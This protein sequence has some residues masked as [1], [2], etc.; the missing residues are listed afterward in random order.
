MSDDKKK[1][2]VLITL[3]V[4]L[5]SVGAFQLIPPPAPAPA[6]KPSA[7]KPPVTA[8]KPS[9]RDATKPGVPKTAEPAKGALATKPGATTGP[10]V[11][12]V[13]PKKPKDAEV[14]EVVAST[15]PNLAVVAPLAPRDPFDVPASV[16]ASNEPVPYSASNAN[17]Q[18]TKGANGLGKAFGAMMKGMVGALPEVK[19]GGTVVEPVHPTPPPAEAAPEP[20]F[21][22]YLVGVIVGRQ[23]AAV[24]QDAQ[25]HQRLITAGSAIDGDSS[26][27]EVRP[28]IAVVKFRGK[29]IQLE[30]KGDHP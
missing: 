4:A 19:A 13:D 14:K 12:I 17:N 8:G 15:A 28:G 9:V 16:M 18:I 11:E 10:T 27:L 25:G 7:Y 30:I 22:Y 6:A 29:Q 21:N 26:V 2:M 23:S 1:T 24:L 5:V 20:T 3:A